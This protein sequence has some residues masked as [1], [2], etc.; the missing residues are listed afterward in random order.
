MATEVNIQESA[1]LK[2][3]EREENT[4]EIFEEKVTELPVNQVKQLE[5]SSY[6]AEIVN[7]PLVTGK[8][9][10]ESG[11]F[12]QALSVTMVIADE[13]SNAPESCNAAKQTEPEDKETIKTEEKA[14]ESVT[15][16]QDAALED[17]KETTIE[18]ATIVADVKEQDLNATTREF[19]KDETEG[20]SVDAQE[21]TEQCET[22]SKNIEEQKSD[23]SVEKI[24]KDEETKE[25]KADVETEK[26]EKNG[27]LQAITTNA[28]IS[29]QTKSQVETTEHE[30]ADTQ[31]SDNPLIKEASEEN[32]HEVVKSKESIEEEADVDVSTQPTLV[33]ESIKIEEPD[34]EKATEKDVREENSPVK[35]EL[36]ISD[37]TIEK[38]QGDIDGVTSS[39]E[40]P[41]V[42]A[43]ETTTVEHVTTTTV[44]LKEHD[45]DEKTKELI[46]EETEDKSLDAT[47][48][49]EECV[50]EETEQ[51]PEESV[52][53][54]EKETTEHGVKEQDFNVL[55]KDQDED[56][57]T[58]A[59][60]VTFEKSL[61]EESHHKEDNEPEVVK[62]E[63]SME[64]EADEGVS[65]QTTL[66]KES[67]KSVEPNDEKAIEKESPSQKDQGDSGGVTSLQE[68]PSVDV[69]ETA[70][71]QHVTT[72]VD[73]KEQDLNEK[74]TEFIKEE[75]EHKSLDAPEVSK[76]CEE[77]AK[78][79][80]DQKPEE[81]VK[82]IEKEETEKIKPGVETEEKEQQ[83][84]LLPAITKDEVKQSAIAT[85]TKD[86]NEHGEKEQEVNV[87][88][89]DE[90]EDDVTSARDV[91]FEK[92][93]QEENDHNKDD[94]T[95]VVTAEESTEKDTEVIKSSEETEQKLLINAIPSDVCIPTQTELEEEA[96]HKSVDV[97]EEIEQYGDGINDEKD[98]KLEEC[99]TET[100]HSTKEQEEHTEEIKPKV[101]AIE[102][103]DVG[104]STQTKSRQEATKNEENAIESDDVQKQKSDNT[105]IN[106]VCEQ[107]DVKQTESKEETQLSDSSDVKRREIVDEDTEETKSSD[108]II[109]D[110]SSSTQ[111]EYLEK[112]IESKEN[113]DETEEG[114]KHSERSNTT[115]NVD[116]TLSKEEELEKEE[117]IKTSE[118]Q[119]GEDDVTSSQPASKEDIKEATIGQHD[120]TVAYVE[121]GQGVSAMPKEILTQEAEDKSIDA[122]ELGQFNEQKVE[123]IHSSLSETTSQNPEDGIK[124]EDEDLSHVNVEGTNDDT[125]KEEKITLEQEPVEEHSVQDEVSKENVTELNKKTEVE[126]QEDITPSS[127][128]SS[129]KDASNSE[130]EKAESESLPVKDLETVSEVQIPEV[131][132]KSED[133]VLKEECFIS[134]TETHLDEEKETVAKETTSDEKTKVQ[135]GSDDVTSSQ[136]APNEDIQETT[137]QHD[138]TVTY[139]VEGQGVS[140]TAKEILKEE[141]EDKSIDV[142]EKS[143][144]LGEPNEQNVEEGKTTTEIPEDEVKKEEKDLSHESVENIN[145]NTTKEEEGAIEHEPVE[146]QSDQDE[147]SKENITDSNE[148]TEVEHQEDITPTA[149]FETST[150]DASNAEKERAESENFPIDE[151]ETV[152]EVQVPELVPR[153]EESLLKEECVI[154]ETKTHLDEEKGAITKEISSDEKTEVQGGGDDVTSSQNASNEDTQ[155]TTIVQH[156]TP[157]AYVEE[158]QCVSATPNEI[159][160][161]ETDG[162][163][164][165]VE[166]T[167]LKLE[168]PNEHNVEETI[169]QN[170]E[171]EIKKGDRDLSHESVEDTKDDAVKE[172]K[173]AVEHEPV[174][175]YSGLDEVSKENVNELN[176]TTEVEP[177]D[178]TPSN[179]LETS[180]DDT[181]N[182]E[183]EKAETKNLPIEDLET[184]SEVQI[185]KLVP[186]SEESVLKEEHRVSE[187]KTHL[188]E[189][190]EIVTKEILS[191]VTSEETTEIKQETVK[192]V[193]EETSSKKVEFEEGL[194]LSDSS[195][196]KIN[197]KEIT[198][199]NDEQK[200]QEVNMSTE[201]QGEDNITSSQTEVAE[202]KEDLQEKYSHNEGNEGDFFKSEERDSEEIKRSVETQE[203][204]EH[205][206]TTSSST[207]IEPNADCVENEYKKDE[208]AKDDE[209]NE[210]VSRDANLEKKQEDIKETDIGEHAT[211]VAS[212]EEGQSLGTTTKEVLG[213][214]EEGNI[215][216]IAQE[217]T[218]QHD[219]GETG[220]GEQKPEEHTEEIKPSVETHEEK[221]ACI[222]THNESQ[223]EPTKNEE[224]VIKHD[225]QKENSDNLF[226]KEVCEE[227]DITKT[228]SEERQVY[229]SSN[230]KTREIV[231]EDTEEI[232]LTDVSSSTETEHKEKSAAIDENNDEETIVHYEVQTEKPQSPLVEVACDATSSKIAESEEEVKHSESS[233]TTLSE[234]ETLRKE[235]I[236][237]KE[238]DIKTSEVKDGGAGVTSSQDTSNEDIK[239]TTIGQYDTTVAHAEEQCVSET[240]KE[241]AIEE[242]EDKLIEAKEIPLELGQ[243]DEQTVEAHP[244]ISETISEN[245]EDEIKKDL[246]HESL[247]DTNDS[248]TKEE[249]GALE[250][251]PVEEHSGLDEVPKENVADSHERTEVKFQEDIT[252]SIPLEASTED[253]SNSEKEKAEIESLPAKDLEIVSEPNTEES[254]LKAECSISKTETYVDEVKEAV[255]EKISSDEKTEQTSE[256]KQETVREVCE[257]TSLEK[258][259]F[260]GVKLSDTSNVEINEKEI[261]TFKDDDQEVNISAKSEGNDNITSSQNEES[262]EKE[263]LQEKNDPNEGNED[264]F[265][266]SG[267]GVH[268]ET[269][270]SAETI[271]DTEHAI[272]TTSSIQIEPTEETTENNGEKAIENDKNEI[273]SREIDLE[274]KLED[275]CRLA[276]TEPKEENI[277][278]KETNE[279]ATRN[280][281]EQESV[282]A[283]LQGGG[284]DVRSREAYN[285][286]TKETS[287][288]QDATTPVHAEEASEQSENETKDKIEQHEESVNKHVYS[289]SETVE[290]S[291]KEEEADAG[292]KEIESKL[293][294]ENQADSIEHRTEI[295]DEAVLTEKVSKELEQSKEQNVDEIK[296]C[297]TETISENTEDRNT[298][299]EDLSNDSVEKIN[300]NI[301]KEEKC[302]SDGITKGNEEQNDSQD[303]VSKETISDLNETTVVEHRED[304]TPSGSLETST[305]DTTFSDKAEAVNEH[306]PIE[307][308]ESVTEEHIPEVM[309]KLE[310]SKTKEES[311]VSATD[312]GTVTKEIS[313]YETLETHETTPQPENSYITPE[314]NVTQ[315]EIEGCGETVKDV[316]LT[317]EIEQ[318]PL[319]IEKEKEINDFKEKIVEEDSYSPELENKSA[320]HQKELV[321]EIS[322]SDSVPAE[323]P[324][325][326]VDGHIGQEDLQGKEDISCVSKVTTDVDQEPKEERI[327]SLEDD[328]TVESEVDLSNRE[329]TAYPL[330]DEKLATQALESDCDVKVP[331]VKEE[332]VVLTTAE[333]T[334]ENNVKEQDTKTNEIS[335]APD[336]EQET[337]TEAPTKSDEAKSS[338]LIVEEKAL[339]KENLE[340][341]GELEPESE[342]V[343]E[344]QVII[345]TKPQPEQSEITCENIT[346]DENSESKLEEEVTL[347]PENEIKSID[348]Q[349]ETTKNI[350]L[351]D[352]VVVETEKEKKV[353]EIERQVSEKDNCP[354][355]LDNTSTLDQK[356]LANEQ[357]EY[358]NPIADANTEVAEV[359]A[360]IQTEVEDIK[361]AEDLSCLSKASSVIETSEVEMREDTEQTTTIKEEVKADIIDEASKDTI[362][363]VLEDSKSSELQSIDRELVSELQTFAEDQK[364][365]NER[366][367][368]N[369]DQGNFGVEVKDVKSEKAAVE[370]VII[371]EVIVEDEKAKGSK[372]IDDTIN[373]EAKLNQLTTETDEVCQIEKSSSRTYELQETKDSV[374][375]TEEPEFVADSLNVKDETLTVIKGPNEESETVASASKLE[376]IATDKEK[377]KLDEPQADDSAKATY[378]SIPSSRKPTEDS[379]IATEIVPE[380]REVSAIL[381]D[382]LPEA[383]PEILLAKHE[384]KITEDPKVLPSL[385][386]D[387][388]DLQK[389]EKDLDYESEVRIADVVSNVENQKEQK[390]ETDESIEAV[391]PVEDVKT[392]TRELD[393]GSVDL[394]APSVIDAT[395]DKANIKTAE[396]PL[397]STCGQSKPI[398][399]ISGVKQVPL[400]F[401]A[402]KALGTAA[403]ED[404]K[405]SPKY[406]PDD[407]IKV[408]QTH[409]E[410]QKHEVPKESTGSKILTEKTDSSNKQEESVAKSL[411]PEA[412]ILKPDTAPVSIDRKE[413][414]ES[415]EP[416]KIILQ[417]PAKEKSEVAK[418]QQVEREETGFKTDEEY[419]EAEDNEDDEKT[420]S[421]SDAPVMV[422]ASKD[423]EVKAHRKSHNILSG[424]GSKVKHSIAK[425]K[426]AIT[427]KSSPTK[428]P[429]AKDHVIG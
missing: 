191:D 336:N 156:D 351:S 341:H 393:V 426:K 210:T 13:H 175:E 144:E 174:E 249:K 128:E 287:I 263:G 248:T 382:N 67:F 205:V 8:P 414:S 230:V 377:D 91:T 284:N 379:E 253:T 256:I 192:E 202:E 219:D 55:E 329:S 317:E 26:A 373:E 376:D 310:D 41:C 114:V 212:S 319:E 271:E 374:E 135:G 247:E 112:A 294:A 429:K 266:K 403:A 226:V 10:D 339:T 251:E 417:E 97:R 413:K 117:N 233:S 242:A 19:V 217:E 275:V 111:T 213:E 46:K 404:L 231:D 239:E 390:K 153:S 288:V 328:A 98:Q 402:P 101:E 136:N 357:I 241:I 82:K 9:M 314:E 28:A 107:I 363:T 22:G 171:D 38:E 140:A 60:E 177:Q 184:V 21:V 394:E 120:T 106:E 295:K 302:F 178:I 44:D 423:I 48:A 261:T 75:T 195:N 358:A 34:D 124:K 344:E 222:S 15:G 264:K 52:E 352:E 392:S 289:S 419:E 395:A 88:E 16:S 1:C 43:E 333:Y 183:K 179:S 391:I 350:I 418:D 126:A 343:I 221:D 304:V 157:V 162:K 94:A 154:S 147:V 25:I 401:D 243:P 412:A 360:E 47:E 380:C 194:K 182:S 375:D 50:K 224:S 274:E 323:N 134:E 7:T 99:V 24:E 349:N 186:K 340:I 92:D 313:S 77:K 378:D 119:V 70:T 118:D 291:I 113:N 406:V 296:T 145:D 115:L 166:E 427:G 306:L 330:E 61:Q 381:T 416:A 56:D 407:L 400:E 215:Y 203:N 133:L 31:K 69:E 5:T 131:V 326:S 298:K 348:S 130:K 66:V 12:F 237:E 168:Q 252:P 89:K 27:L 338:D 322:N 189:E 366:C 353:H 204:T 283:E 424:V 269:K 29:T 197:E 308:L 389:H 79:E 411:I 347:A 334:D 198:F 129:T 318:V 201:S 285:D 278:N 254:V 155:E 116:E 105:V 160:K 20:K 139:V 410:I 425:V 83:D 257:E 64:E 73:F 293:E 279:E 103:K 4:S 211:T 282:V 148:T 102:E 54:T 356:E 173:S 209:E 218:E 321:H 223:E 100:A 220:E 246:S 307:D 57:I 176:K 255:T 149:S 125:T 409:P 159:L 17:I 170:P 397:E 53:K 387:G 354:T 104:I 305:E 277:E 158:E 270:S 316:I 121:E 42:D 18:H 87:L 65:T 62:V 396:V 188:D 150:E 262:E 388:I 232:K 299:D 95:E 23:E 244:Y 109:T 385:E 110:V 408:S 276:Q 49:S 320:E 196:I 80:M 415:A 303:E 164:I 59:Q 265:I 229:D 331:Q 3:G 45:L 422:E 165:D 90:G 76:E 51:N 161:E 81:S 309:P 421:Y 93:L 152:S 245:L 74:P 142:E 398:E 127:F 235:E 84:E 96:K 250:H 327:S 216:A 199:K 33:K 355:E 260:E 190:K 122:K 315:S 200:D 141:P 71:V 11:I 234:N 371:N 332:Y 369:E 268:E 325:V 30:E 63:G 364:K 137:G 123:E 14:S 68:S 367:I 361:A 359:K 238:D 386:K 345:E 172:E 2:K 180:T 384:D 280:D 39:L 337:V 227:S 32:V 267:A 370:D 6:V 225:D 372:S 346:H 163:P 214:A 86:E 146:E 108:V 181:T 290:E 151:P 37:S 169:I 36:E 300:E 362:V 78:E 399:E 187:T 40:P 301:T 143:L 236:L 383:S 259:E 286:D 35:A 206:I 420:G 208:K 297:L 292:N 58:H 324:E 342:P 240:P 311:P 368:E 207:Q 335:S 258:A 273:V 72:A 85:A 185:P 193:C 405:I 167:S 312:I 365:I 272:A 138:T 428:S 228:E 281:K 132:P